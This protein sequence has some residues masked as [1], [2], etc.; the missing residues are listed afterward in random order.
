MTRCIHQL[1]L[2]LHILRKLTLF[3]VRTLTCSGVALLS[4][5]L[6]TL[7]FASVSVN[8]GVLTSRCPSVLSWPGPW[9]YRRRQAYYPYGVIKIK[10]SRMDNSRSLI[11]LS[12]TQ[13]PDWRSSDWSDIHPALSPPVMT[14]RT[15]DRLRPTDAAATTQLMCVFKNHILEPVNQYVLNKRICAHG[16]YSMPYLHSPM[17]DERSGS[18]SQQSL[19]ESRIYFLQFI[20]LESITGLCMV[21]NNHLH[22]QPSL[23]LWWTIIL[24]LHIYGLCEET[25]VLGENLKRQREHATFIQKDHVVC[26]PIELSNMNMKM[27]MIWTIDFEIQ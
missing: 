17:H 14:A 22:A 2:I 1:S 25:G 13:P 4:T 18:Q 16:N 26:G 11:S 10:S 12:Q 7:G 20:I 5:L 15:A 9:A 3:F 21:A 8:T 27:H 23:N 6:L 24:I 19:G